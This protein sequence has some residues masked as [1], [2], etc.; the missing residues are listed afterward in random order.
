VRKVEQRCRLGHLDDVRE[1]LSE[2]IQ[3][4]YCFSSAQDLVSPGAA[5]H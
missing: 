1:A 2:A 4:R 5:R 3:E